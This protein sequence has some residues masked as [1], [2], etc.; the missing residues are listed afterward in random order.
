MG[1]LAPLRVHNRQQNTVDH[2]RRNHPLLAIS[3]ID[4]EAMRRKNVIENELGVFESDSMLSQ[5]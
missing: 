1:S 3:G 5:I 4:I 2:S